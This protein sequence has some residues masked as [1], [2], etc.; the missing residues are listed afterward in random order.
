M[1]CDDSR[2]MYQILMMNELKYIFNT[3]KKDTCQIPF[4][5]IYHFNPLF[6]VDVIDLHRSCFTWFKFT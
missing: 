4:H 6:R 2:E 3:K 1:P 5:A